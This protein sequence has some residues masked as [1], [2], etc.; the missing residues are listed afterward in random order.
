[1]A[2][3]KIGSADGDVDP[4]PA[5]HD[6]PARNGLD[7]RTRP[8]HRD[9]PRLQPDPIPQLFRHHESPCLVLPSTGQLAVP[10]SKDSA[11]R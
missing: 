7:V 10:A 9:L 8:V 5:F 11:P 1:M 4:A 3:V 2:V 6:A